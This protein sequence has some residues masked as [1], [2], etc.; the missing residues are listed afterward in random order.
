M[1][2]WCVIFRADG[3]PTQI[4]EGT[5]MDMLALYDR[6]S[7]GWT[8]VILCPMLLD[9]RQPRAGTRCA[10]TSHRERLSFSVVDAACDAFSAE[11]VEAR[12]TPDEGLIKEVRRALESFAA[13]RWIAPTAT[14][15]A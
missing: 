2:R 9:G 11:L 5:L 6:L 3:G 1:N 7:Q 15:P 13:V 8:E 14:R 12:G 10:S 4:H